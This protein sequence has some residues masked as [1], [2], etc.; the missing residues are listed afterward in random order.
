MAR[1]WIAAMALIGCGSDEVAIPATCNGAVE[2][3]ARSYDQVSYV[4]AH[5]AMS[6]QED[7]WLYPNQD[8]GIARQ[9][10]DGVRG[11][12]LDVHLTDNGLAY[13]CH[14]ICSLGQTPLVDGLTTIRTF[15]AANRGEVVTIIFE[16]YVDAAQ[17]AE[18]FD[19]SGLAAYA[20][21]HPAGAPWPTLRELIDS[22]QR[23]VVFTDAGGG[24]Y[25][26]YLDV[27]RYAWETDFSARAVADFS[28]E[29]NRGDAEASLFILNHFLTDTFAVPD[30]AATVNATPFV[31][32][33]ARECMQSSGRL[34]TFVTVDFYDRGGVAAA[35]AALNQLP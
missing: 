4:T 5:N 33:R 14:A 24:S 22:D 31:L 12:M 13:L 32:D 29:K 27:W 15:L 2:L 7:G 17:V 11:L 18:A 20:Y 1:A 8:F 23:V 28:C 3:C 9:L 21:A 19:A 16:S 34:P 6:N 10:D 25:D 35:V 26:W 30:Q